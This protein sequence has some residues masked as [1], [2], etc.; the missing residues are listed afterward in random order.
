VDQKDLFSTVSGWQNFRD[1]LRTLDKKGKGNAFEL[2]TKYYLQID[3]LYATKLTNVWLLSEVP[4]EIAK[5][6]RLPAPDNGI[7]LIADI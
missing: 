4:S 6:L 7:D 1:K 2:L 5:K 3:P